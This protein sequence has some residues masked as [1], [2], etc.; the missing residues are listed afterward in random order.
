[1]TSF[2]AKS[3][4]SREMA[5]TSAPAAQTLQLADPPPE[6][7]VVAVGVG[8]ERW[9]CAGCGLRCAPCCHPGMSPGGFTLR[10][11]FRWPPVDACAGR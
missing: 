9:G 4:D 1:M 6:Q 2:E 8:S 3:M 5:T 11:R 10:T 7:P